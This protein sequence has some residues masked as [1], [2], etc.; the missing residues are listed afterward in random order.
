[1]ARW[2]IEKT[3]LTHLLDAIRLGLDDLRDETIERGGGSGG[4]AK[5]GAQTYAHLRRLRTYLQRFVGLVGESAE[6]DF[7]EDDQNLVASCA[8]HEVGKLDRAFAEAGRRESTAPAGLADRRQTLAD[9]CI[10]LATRRIEG[11]TVAGGKQQSPTV[12]AV[13]REVQHRLMSNPEG[14][15]LA[16][17]RDLSSDLHTLP[18]LIGR[19]PV[20]PE[21]SALA[22]AAPSF[23]TA[24]RAVVPPPIK[25][26]PPA[27][28]K[29]NQVD[30]AVAAARLHAGV[31]PVAPSLHLDLPSSMSSAPSVL[32]FDARHL[33]DPRLRALLQLD[34]AAYRRAVDA[35]DHRLAMAHLA[36]IIEGATIDFALANRQ[37]L[38]LGGS[39]ETW[40]LEAILTRLLENH[41]TPVNPNAMRFLGLART[42]LRPGHQLAAPMAITPDIQADFEEFAYRVVTAV[43]AAREVE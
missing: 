7:S 15:G 23:S 4:Y 8:L 30:P 21:P 12:Q 39:P 9:W 24:S 19:T 25:P 22:P 1:M 18:G 40:N 42:I 5:T 34:L 27:P 31:S 2:E 37:R 28:A 32:D 35:K 20:A 17:V 29:V 13:H 10:R 3:A 36:S 43:A 6:L 16:L 41:F 26:V 14:D 38:T 33:L 11:I